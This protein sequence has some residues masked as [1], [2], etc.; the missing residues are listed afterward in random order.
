VTRIPARTPLAPLL[1]AT[2]KRLGSV[3]FNDV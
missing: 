1:I 3:A 2:F